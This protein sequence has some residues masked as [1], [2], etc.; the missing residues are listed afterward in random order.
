MISAHHGLHAIFC[1]TTFH[2]SHV[3]VEA[4]RPQSES[5]DRFGS[6]CHHRT[7]SSSYCAF[8]KG[9]GDSLVTVG[10]LSTYFGHNTKCEVPTPP[11]AAPATRLRTPFFHPCF[12]RKNR[13]PAQKSAAILPGT[14]LLSH[15]K[16][17]VTARCVRI[18][19]TPTYRQPA[20]GMQRA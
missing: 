7:R 19:T 17:P 11:A 20:C 15:Q 8:I 13:Q 6:V 2:R 18:S 12:T 1:E 16:S 3:R 9:A 4:H 14:L 5:S 10:P